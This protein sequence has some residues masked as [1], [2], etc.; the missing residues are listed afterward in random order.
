MFRQINKLF[1][2]F[3]VQVKKTVALEKE[4]AYLTSIIS[5]L[6]EL[7]AY[8]FEEMYLND[9]IIGIVFSKDRAM[10]LNALL[11]SYFHFTKSAVP[12]RVLYTT[13]S[14]DH[15]ESYNC[16]RQEF[17]SFPV[18]FVR[19]ISFKEDLKRVLHESQSSRVFFMTDDAIF[20][21][22]Y[23]LS[24][25][26]QFNPLDE[27]FSL[28]LGK[29]MGYSFA[30]NREQ[31]IPELIKIARNDSASYSWIWND[32]RDS[33]DWCYPLSVDG[34]FFCKGEL[35]IMLRHIDFKNPNSLEANLQLFNPVFLLRKGVCYE[36]A[37]YVNI[38]CNIVQQDFKNIYTGTFDVA[39][40]VKLYLAGKRIDWKQY[41]DASPKEI[42]HSRFVFN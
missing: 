26:L 30:L 21:G 10:Q 41:A 40:L 9:E 6:Q 15:S 38:P 36:N 14:A 11:N 2:F 8:R 20:S 32:M 27:I 1:S 5:G 16:L 17:S 33:P 24:D 42:Q 31:S 22:S 39:E 19:E 37:K 4:R 25:V 29:D 23:N 7:Y 34:T 18:E 35:E 13:S 12:L 28:R 3:G